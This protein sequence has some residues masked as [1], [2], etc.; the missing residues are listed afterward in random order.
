M[1]K[2]LKRGLLKLGLTLATSLG[3][4]IITENVIRSNSTSDMKPLTKLACFLGS[5]A[6]I[7][8]V[9]GAANRYA[10]NLFDDTAE[11]YDRLMEHDGNIA[12]VF[13]DYVQR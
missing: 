2:V 11:L 1:N 6:L 12:E 8:V 7:G 4:G 5:I 13:K 10:E 3:A 9:A